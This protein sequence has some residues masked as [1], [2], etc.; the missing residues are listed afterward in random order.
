MRLRL[1]RASRA[2]SS[3][4]TVYELEDLHPSSVT[5]LLFPLIEDNG[6]THE[7]TALP[8][9]CTVQAPHWARPKPKRGPC[10]QGCQAAR[11][12]DAWF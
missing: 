6:V 2:D 11:R 12:G 10:S 8:S 7:L 1:L 3:L 4:D 9:T 5:T